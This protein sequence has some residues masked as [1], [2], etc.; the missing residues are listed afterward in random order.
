[1]QSE[2]ELHSS[3]PFVL[4]RDITQEIL[5]EGGTGQV[6]GTVSQGFFEFKSFLGF[7]KNDVIQD[8]SHARDE[9]A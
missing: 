1:M 3:L 2:G 8:V 4:H 6:C 5:K 7:F 9:H